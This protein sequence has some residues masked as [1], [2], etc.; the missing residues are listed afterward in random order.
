M[1]NV[2]Q[3]FYQVIGN[4]E[5]KSNTFHN[6]EEAENVAFATKGLVIEIV[7]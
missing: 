1:E 3:I 2:K 5:F 7:K 4:G 6:L